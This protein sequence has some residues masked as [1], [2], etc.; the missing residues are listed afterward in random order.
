MRHQLYF[1][2]PL[3]A[4]GIYAGS[5][6]A[7]TSY[8]E[9]ILNP[10]NPGSDV[11]ATFFLTLNG[12]TLTVKE[13]ATGLEPGE[14]HMQ[15]I[16]GLTGADEAN[17]TPISSA[18]FAALD[19]D[20]NGYVDL[21]EGAVSYGPILLNLDQP[22][23]SMTFPMPNA[24]GVLDY[25]ET[26]DLSNPALIAAGFTE[27]DLFPLTDREIVIHGESVPAGVVGADPGSELNG[28]AGYKAALPV[29][30]GMIF[31]VSGVPEPSTW[32]MMLL[33][34]AAIGFA[35]YRAQRKSVS[36]AT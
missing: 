20:H 32:A 27:A 29:A 24:A 33:G 23:G 8:Y 12:N 36:A 34:F 4:A 11:H 13:H 16:H 28:I 22:P 7:A 31:A 25:N 6:R 9:A 19:V 14:M 1:V 35:G 5:A 10:I 26:F 18:N 21:A 30:D 17:T 2:I 3:V 15:H